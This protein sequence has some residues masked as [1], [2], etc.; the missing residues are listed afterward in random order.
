MK[1]FSH[2]HRKQLFYWLGHHID[3]PTPDS[4][5]ITL[6]DASRGKYIE[7]LKRALTQGLWLKTPGTPDRLGNVPKGSHFEVSR[8]ITCFTEWQVNESEPHTTRYGRLGLGFPRDFV[9]KRGGHPV[10]YVKGIHSG[11]Q[12][13]KNLL[14]LRDFLNDSRLSKTFDPDEIELH[15]RR[16]DYITHFAKWA[17]KPPAPRLFPWR[18]SAKTPAKK[19]RP[20]LGAA[21]FIEEANF[22]RRFGAPQELLEEREWRIVHHS[23]FKKYFEKPGKEKPAP[24]FYIPFQTGHELFTVVLPDNKT[25]NMVMNDKFFIRKFYPADAPHVTVLSLDDVNTF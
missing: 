20:S 13:T 14:T 16:L 3:Y 7:S 19:S 4:K 24:D 21:G 15:R 1:K 22:N 2:V 17:R 11:D 10:V 23:S 5:R 8:P 9:F 25:V 18:R 6:D 12:Y